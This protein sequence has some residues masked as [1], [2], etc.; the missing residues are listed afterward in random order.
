M[1][2]S[3]SRDNGKTWT[4]CKPIGFSGHCPYLHRTVDGTIILAHRN[5]ATDL[6]YSTDECRTWSKNVRVD[7]RAG[8]YPSMVNLKDGSVLIVFYDDGGQS[9]IPG[10]APLGRSPRARECKPQ[11]KRFCT[12]ATIHHILCCR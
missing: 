2:W 5:P 12:T 9:N 3:R 7:S 1:H 10:S 8:A 4:V 11:N 6:H